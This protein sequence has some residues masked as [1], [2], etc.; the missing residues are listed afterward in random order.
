MREFYFRM[1][2]LKRA[3]TIYTSCIFY[4]FVN[5]PSAIETADQEHIFQV[6]LGSIYI[7]LLVGTSLYCYL[8]AK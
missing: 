1:R 2:A 5:P 6:D 7:K 8:S 3:D 4:G